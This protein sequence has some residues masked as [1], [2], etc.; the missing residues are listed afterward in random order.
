MTISTYESDNEARRRVLDSAEKLFNQRGYSGVTVKDLASALSIKPASLYYH[1]PGGKE[2]LFVKVLDRCLERHAAELN[3]CVT[4]GYDTLGEQLHAASMVLLDRGP[5]GFVRMLMSDMDELEPD[6]SR[7]LTQKAYA[8]LMRPLASI[9]EKGVASGDL[10]SHTPQLV[11]GSF[12][13]ALDSL[14]YASNRQ[15]A[16]D[17]SLTDMVRELVDIYL[18]GLKRKVND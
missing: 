3:E 4:R 6:N 12:L 16:A 2:E 18:N 7:M 17:M 10:R 13:S 11:T 1:A 5:L 14:W 9:F 8:A 15:E